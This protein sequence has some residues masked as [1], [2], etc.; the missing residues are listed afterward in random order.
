[1]ARCSWPARRSWHPRSTRTRPAE[2]PRWCRSSSLRS[3]AAPSRASTDSSHRGTTSKQLNKETDARFVRLSGLA[4]RRRRRARRYHRHDRRIFDPYR[5]A[6]P[7]WRVRRRR[8]P[9]VRARRLAHRVRRTGTSHRIFRDAPHRHGRS[10]RRHDNG[11]RRPAPALHHS[12]VGNHLQDSAASKAA[13]SPPWWRSAPV[14]RSRS[15]PAAREVRAACCS[16]RSSERPIS[17]WQD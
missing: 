15:E 14:L 5:V 16:G 6:G 3:L 11:C 12:R 4:G 1:M 13:M 7:L 17:C 10:V 9:H 2:H 8:D